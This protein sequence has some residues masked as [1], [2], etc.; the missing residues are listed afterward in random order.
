MTGL[1]TFAQS[2]RIFGGNIKH[3][4]Q[5]LIQ[6]GPAGYRRHAR[7]R[8]VQETCAVI[9]ELAPYTKWAAKEIRALDI[10]KLLA[11]RSKPRGQEGE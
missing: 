4:L 10:K 5:I 9:A 7:A 2:A 6:S 11:P 3:A 1:S 8:K